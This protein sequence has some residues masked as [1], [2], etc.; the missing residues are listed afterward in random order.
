MSSDYNTDFT[1]E[2]A[3]L[4]YNGYRCAWIKADDDNNPWVKFDLSQSR[5]AIRVT[6]GKRCDPN[7]HYVTSFHVSLSNNDAIRSYIGTDVHAVYE[8]IMA[9]WWFDIEVSACY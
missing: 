9:T 4:E 8:G 5:V 3:R 2:K 1:A 7:Q 6:I